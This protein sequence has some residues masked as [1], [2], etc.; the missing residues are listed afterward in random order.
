MYIKSFSKIISVY[1]C[2]FLLYNLGKRLHH[3]TFHECPMTFCSAQLRHRIDTMWRARGSCISRNE[4]FV[5]L[6][7]VSMEL[8]CTWDNTFRIP[9]HKCVSRNRIPDA[10]KTSKKIKRRCN[11]INTNSLNIYFDK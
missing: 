2:S 8:G 5:R 4:I 9:R 6:F 7:Q 1:K 11:S 3:C 10:E